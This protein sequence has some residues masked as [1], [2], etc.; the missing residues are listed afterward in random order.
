MLLVICVVVNVLLVDVLTYVSF[1]CCVC[2]LDL[3]AGLLWLRFAIT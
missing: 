1:V 3:L 2:I